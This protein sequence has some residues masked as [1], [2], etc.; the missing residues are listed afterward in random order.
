MNTNNDSAM[1]NRPPQRGAS[2]S[3]TVS[4]YLDLLDSQREA[5]FA[6][7]DEL[8][9]AQIWQ[10]PALRRRITRPENATGLERGYQ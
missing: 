5:A 3:S 10:R 2:Q 8:S 7:C 6:A 9:D 1:V 4:Q